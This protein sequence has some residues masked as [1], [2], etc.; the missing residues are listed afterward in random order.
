MLR[1]ASP[2][3]ASSAGRQRIVERLSAIDPCVPATHRERLAPSTL[4]D[5]GRL[6][7]D[8]VVG[9][10]AR[11]EDGW[12][13][14]LAL[15]GRIEYEPRQLAR[16]GRLRAERQAHRKGNAIGAANEPRRDRRSAGLAVRLRASFPAGTGGRPARRDDG[17]REG[18]EV[19]TV[20]GQTDSRG[21]RTDPGINHQ[22]QPARWHDWR[23]LLGRETWAEFCERKG[24]PQFIEL[25]RDPYGIGPFTATQRAPDG[26]RELERKGA[27]A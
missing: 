2:K 21:R 25:H 17:V 5:Q 8:R 10:R 27:H 11:Q 18:G 24:V 23:L 9:S 22:S 26:F 12:P 15:E 1:I 4:L 3:R 20:R 6:R 7:D 16:D 13:D 14:H 19:L